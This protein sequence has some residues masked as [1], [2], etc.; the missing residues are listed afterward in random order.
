MKEIKEIF[1]EK[2]IRDKKHKLNVNSDYEI[3]DSLLNQLE[4]GITSEVLEKIPTEIFQY[5]TQITIHGIFKRF[6]NPYNYKLVFQNKNK[7]IGV[8]WQAIDLEKKKRIANR[9]KKAGWHFFSNSTESYFYQ[10]RL[11]KDLEE[12]PGYVKEFKEILGKVEKTLFQG[13]W[14]IYF[15]TDQW[16]SR[17]VECRITINCI[18]EK[19]ID[20]LVSQLKGI[21]QEE[22]EKIEAEK[23]AE[24]E[25]KHQEYL[26][27]LRIEKEKNIAIFNELWKEYS[28]LIER[29]ENEL[30][31]FIKPYLSGGEKRTIRFKK[32]NVSK[33]FVE[34]SE[35]AD[36]ENLKNVKMIKKM[37]YTTL[38][39]LYKYTEVISCK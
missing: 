29:K 8:K 17:S 5:Y 4:C 31:T 34:I 38:P 35:I 18:Y 3:T 10:Y 37:K 21:S 27:F 13:G 15:I 16:G 2:I 9:I 26:E 19:N 14:E 7:S 25:K 11:V 33:C 36:Y 30:G 1:S 12:V 32:M 20:L 24:A 23:E 6:F 28:F 39:K 22:Y